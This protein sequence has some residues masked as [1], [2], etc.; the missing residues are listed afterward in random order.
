MKIMK[1]L[2]MMTSVIGSLLC[3]F[4][5]AQPT[6]LPASRYADHGI[7]VVSDYDDT[8]KISHIRGN[9]LDIVRRA[10]FSD[11]FYAGSEKLISVFERGANPS[12]II[13]AS[14][15]TDSLYHHIGED[16]RENHFPHL[17]I[18][19]KDWSSGE[20]TPD[21]KTSVL[22]SLVGKDL[23]LMG[24]DTEQDP[25]TF[26]S[27]MNT[28]SANVMAIYIHRITKDRPLPVGVESYLT[29]F[30]IAYLE[31][32][33]G[34]MRSSEALEISEQVLAGKNKWIL[35]S[36]VSCE[37]AQSRCALELKKG[38]SADAEL[39]KACL[40]IQTRLD[41]ICSA[42]GKSDD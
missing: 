38:P 29:S 16:L 27:F 7:L 12:N 41:T 9:K 21:F 26:T 34:R 30:D 17:K 18:L 3:P 35:P 40:A 31:N 33:A 11:S 8:L 28:H 14:G 2:L 42:R 22:K 4:A 20:S 24:D 5:Y 39:D 10:L 15:S 1:Y 13:V 6:A 36:F 32:K 23:I 25:E 19:L 37:M